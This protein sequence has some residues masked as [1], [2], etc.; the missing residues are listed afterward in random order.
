MRTL[1][2]DN[3]LREGGAGEPHRSQR[4]MRSCAELFE[5]RPGLSHADAGP[6]SAPST[7]GAIKSESQAARPERLREIVFQT[8]DKSRGKP[9]Q[10][11]CHFGQLATLPRPFCPLAPL[12][13]CPLKFFGLTLGLS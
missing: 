6:A 3:L 7:T 4:Q 12:L 5:R 9:P 8:N 2:I 10:A 13:L 11:I 1:F